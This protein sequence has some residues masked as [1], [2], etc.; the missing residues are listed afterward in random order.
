MPSHVGPC[1]WCGGPQ[2]W[3]LIHGIVYESCCS[4]CLPLPF[5]SF[6]PPP[7]S[8]SESTGADPSELF[9][10]GGVEGALE[11]GETETSTTDVTELPFLGSSPHLKEGS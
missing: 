1:E 7:D 3:T 8:E 11:G 2:V 9:G 6:V 5:D 10:G 4:G